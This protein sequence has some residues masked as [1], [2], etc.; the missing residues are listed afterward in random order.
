MPFCFPHMSYLSLGTEVAREGRNQ[1]TVIAITYITS[2]LTTTHSE[3][4]IK[5][6]EK[7]SNLVELSLLYRAAKYELTCGLNKQLHTS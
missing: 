6:L 2:Q 1:A 4:S 7:M 5:I 3:L